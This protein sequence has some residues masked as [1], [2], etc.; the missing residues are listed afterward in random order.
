MRS[1]QQVLIGM[2]LT[3]LLSTVVSSL[4]TAAPPGG[5]EYEP[6][7][8]VR[9]EMAQDGESTAAE[10]KRKAQEAAEAIAAE[11]GERKRKAKEAADMIEAERSGRV[12]RL[13]K[14]EEAAKALRLSKL[15]SIQMVFVKGGCFQMGD[16]SGVGDDDELPVHEVCVSDYYLS[17]TEVTQQLWEAVAECHKPAGRTE[18]TTIS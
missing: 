4:A 17:E 5:F 15:P 13:R 16:F 6:D 10:R 2:V 9:I 3:F 7:G 1:S 14:S 11:A 8:P 18:R 12:E